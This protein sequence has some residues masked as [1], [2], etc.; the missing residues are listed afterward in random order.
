MAQVKMETIWL[1]DP[2]KGW[3]AVKDD[4][5]LERA[6]GLMHAQSAAVAE[7]ARHVAAGELDGLSCRRVDSRGHVLEVEVTRSFAHGEDL[8]D[9]MG[10][11]PL[12]VTWFD[13]VGPTGHVECSPT[14][15]YYEFPH[16]DAEVK[17]WNMEGLV[18]EEKG[19][20]MQEMEQGP[21]ENGEWEEY[22]EWGQSYEEELA[23]EI[24]G[25][26]P[27]A[28]RGILAPSVA[29]AWPIMSLDEIDEAIA[30]S[31]R[32]GRYLEAQKLTVSSSHF[33]REDGKGAYI[34]R[35]GE[36]AARYD[37][38]SD[39]MEAIG[40]EQL[41]ALFGP[42]PVAFR[43]FQNRDVQRDCLKALREN[44]YFYNPATGILVDPYF[45]GYDLDTREVIVNSVPV[46]CIRAAYE[47][48]VEKYPSSAEDVMLG[49]LEAEGLLRSSTL[50]W[51]PATGTERFMER[52]AWT[53]GRDPAWVEEVTLNEETIAQFEEAEL[54]GAEVIDADANGQREEGTR[55]KDVQKM[56]PLTEEEL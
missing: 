49:D 19:K 24:D 40:E 41:D 20:E 11:K 2:F 39:L 10:A 37:T 17:A 48:Y 45:D 33:A 5:S 55:G 47:K 32:E 9:P 18:E 35:D 52:L 30:K 12:R 1:R 13:E 54:A 6:L 14:E 34:V 28:V 38:A 44:T 15:V 7:A 3:P 46:G 4:A 51:I 42:E 53:I 36:V 26:D 23:D 50:T 21:E 25:L 43:R 16:D 22:G 27:V 31:A 56:Q 8:D 29:E